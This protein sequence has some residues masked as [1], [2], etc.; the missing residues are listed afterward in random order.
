MNLPYSVYGRTGGLQELVDQISP[1][2]LFSFKT[3]P[4]QNSVK[5]S[6]WFSLLKE[7]RKRMKVFGNQFKQVWIQLDRGLLPAIGNFQISFFKPLCCL[8]STVVKTVELRQKASKICYFLVM[9]RWFLEK[10]LW[11][12]STRLICIEH[13][14][15]ICKIYTYQQ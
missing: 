6:C 7:A 3:L 13:L 12:H 14:E 15:T 2:S 9:P 5:R 10:P 11:Y 8:D 1:P 4:R